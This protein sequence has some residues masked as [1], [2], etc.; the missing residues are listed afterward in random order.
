MQGKS[1]DEVV[2]KIRGPID[3]TVR[4]TLRRKAPKEK[5]DDPDRTTSVDLAIKRR[6]ISYP[7]VQQ[8]I[9]EG[10]V[11]YVSLS[12]FNEVCDEKLDAVLAEFNRAGVKGLILDLRANPGGLLQSAQEIASRFVPEGNPV[13]WIEEK[14]QQQTP[15]KSIKDRRRYNGPLIVLVNRNSASAS[16]IV[17]GAVKDYGAGTV[18]G[19]T[20][21]G[22]GLVQTVVPLSDRSA[23]V[24]TTAKYLTPKKKDI[25]RTLDAR[26]GIAPDVEVAV[27][28]ED[29]FALNDVQ[30]KKALELMQTRIGYQPAADRPAAVQL[31][32]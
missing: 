17:A 7:I 25:N 19:T 11:G 18:V 6:P 28:E 30:L 32:R 22:K 27:S 3:T 13:V 29:F 10:N 15:L 16:E 12:Q 4:L 20:T 5:P 14:G 31:P 1:V 2:K 24:I 23:V 21:F 8:K 9:L 26:G